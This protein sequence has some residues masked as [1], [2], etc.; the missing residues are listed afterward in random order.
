[1]ARDMQVIWVK[2]EP[3]Y[4]CARDW[5]TQISLIAFN[6][7]I[8]SGREPSTCRTSGLPQ[9]RDA[10]IATKARSAAN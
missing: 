4:F 9:I 5:T 1:M 3:E 2:S 7:S 8:W 6:K 10:P